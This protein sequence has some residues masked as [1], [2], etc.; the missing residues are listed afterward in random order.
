M[1]W[2]WRT[3]CG[4]EPTLGLAIVWG[5]PGKFRALPL[6]PEWSR[7]WKQEQVV[8]MATLAMPMG[9]AVVARVLMCTEGVRHQC[10]TMN[11]G[12]HD[13]S[14]APHTCGIHTHTHN[15][16]RSICKPTVTRQ[17]GRSP[18]KC[19]RGGQVATCHRNPWS[20]R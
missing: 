18:P 15:I 16:C 11:D 14:S 1:G 19:A 13:L 4:D 10:G 7:I 2:R 3:A 17:S 9:N 8:S 5:P 20:Q 12:Q 6:R